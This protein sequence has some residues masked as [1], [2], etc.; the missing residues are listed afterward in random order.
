M[1]A[2]VDAV[3]E[4]ARHVLGDRITRTS[5]CANITRTARTPSRRSAGRRGLHRN[6][7]G[8][9]PAARA[10]A[11]RSRAGRAMGRRHL[12]GGA[13]N[14]GA[15]RHHARPV[16]HDAHPPGQPAGHG[17]PGG[18]RGD[19]QAAQRASARPGPVFPGRSR[20]RGL[21]AGR[22]VRDPR[23]RHQ[24]GAL[25][26]DPRKRHGPDRGAG[27]RAGDPH[28]RAGAQVRRPATT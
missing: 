20:H 19:P 2:S 13:R 5:P 7:R 27:R 6:H 17:L 11:M 3:I 28:R 15:R 4:A 26:H 25:R 10:C 9:G 24:C 22:H 14:A 1:P 8:S 12:A 18:G 23:L 21:H 16:A